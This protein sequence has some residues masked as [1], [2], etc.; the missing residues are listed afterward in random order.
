MAI[1]SPGS[2]SVDRLLAQLSD[3][4]DSRF[5]RLGSFQNTYPTDVRSSVDDNDRF[6]FT[7]KTGCPVNLNHPHFVAASPQRR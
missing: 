7:N 2:A 6:G 1:G 4:V 3:D 5:A